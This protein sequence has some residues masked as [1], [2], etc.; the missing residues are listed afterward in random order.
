MSDL[1][2]KP[3]PSDQSRTLGD[4][5]GPREVSGCGRTTFGRQATHDEA[6]KAKKGPNVINT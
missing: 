2:R 5:D 1:E 3:S 6:P 4:T